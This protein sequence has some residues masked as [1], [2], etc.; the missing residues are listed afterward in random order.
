MFGLSGQQSLGFL[1]A[2]K[3]F[4]KLRSGLKNPKGFLLIVAICSTIA[5]V[6]LLPG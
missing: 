1:I 3:E 4:V 5:T 6:L 2:T